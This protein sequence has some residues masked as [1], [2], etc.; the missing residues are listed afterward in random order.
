MTLDTSTQ[1]QA[2]NL[3]DNPE[4]ADEVYDAKWA[5]N[6]AGVTQLLLD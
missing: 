6:T 4:V 3:I 1:A 5:M 2:L